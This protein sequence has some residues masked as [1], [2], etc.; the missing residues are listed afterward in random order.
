VKKNIRLFGLVCVAAMLAAPYLHAMDRDSTCIQ[1]NFLAYGLVGAGI[2][3]V[4]LT[5]VNNGL[6]ARGLSTFREFTPTIAIGGHKEFDRMIVESNVTGLFWKDRVNSS[7]R[8]SLWIGNIVWN[9]GFNV[10]PSSLP[11]I[12][13]PFAGI[14]AGLNGIHFRSN[15]KTLSDILVSKDPNSTLWQTAFLLNVGAGADLR[16]AVGDR[17][18]GAVIGVRGGYAFDPFLKSKWYSDGIRVTGLSP[19]V[20]SGAFMRLVLGR[21]GGYGRGHK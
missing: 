2:S 7:V 18:G 14:G 21:W 10:L 3:W 9:T 1:R 8:T 6:A 12:A 20:Q 13:F 11:I 15:E 19:V 4:N 16:I 5:G 17:N